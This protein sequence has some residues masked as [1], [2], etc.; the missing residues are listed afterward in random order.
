[1]I[2]AAFDAG[3]FQTIANSALQA[4]GVEV[5][6][7]TPHEQRTEP[8][9]FFRVLQEKLEVDDQKLLT[10]RVD[11]KL[12]W[13]DLAVT[14]LGSADVSEDTDASVLCLQSTTRASPTARV[15]ARQAQRRRARPECEPDQPLNRRGSA[16]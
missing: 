5:R 6:S 11:R 12:S 3:D 16:C 13:R 8:K 9:N 7:T 14:T 15:N 1:V 10:L 2:R 4:T